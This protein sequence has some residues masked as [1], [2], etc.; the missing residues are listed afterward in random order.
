M[1]RD[2]PMA[3]VRHLANLGLG[4]SPGNIQCRDGHADSFGWSATSTVGVYA[5]RAASPLWVAPRPGVGSVAD[6]SI[7]VSLDAL[8]TLREGCYGVTE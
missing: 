4:D 7:E 6:T 2:H 5:R 1:A 8:M 3:V